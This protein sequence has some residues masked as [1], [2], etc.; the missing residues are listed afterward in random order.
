MQDFFQVSDDELDVNYNLSWEQ[1]REM[2]RNGIFFGAHTVTH[3][4]LTRVPEEQAR[5]EIAKSKERIE[6]EIHKPVYGF[7]YPNGTEEDF[8]ASIVE[9]LKNC[10]FAY[11]VTTIWGS[12]NAR[13]DLFLL[14]RVEPN[15]N[16]D[17]V[18]FECLLSG[19]FEFAD[20]L[21]TK[22]RI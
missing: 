5:E 20:K 9:I 16:D 21:R 13:S 1:I 11:A 14:K 15:L 3:P 19:G 8:D 10:G 7:C 6:S 18:N 17:I 4:I 12:N 22:L 2:S